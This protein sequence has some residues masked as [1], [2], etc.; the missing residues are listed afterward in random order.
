[1][2]AAASQWPVQAA[3]FGATQWPQPPA[4]NGTLQWPAG[5]PVTNGASQWPAGPAPLSVTQWPAGPPITNGAT[6]WPAGPPITNG[7]TQWPAGQ[8]LTNG[9]TQWPAA[10]TTW[11]GPPP[12]NNGSMQWPAGPAGFQMPPSGNVPS[13]Q[14]SSSW[15]RY[16]PHRI[17]IVFSLHYMWSVYLVLDLVRYWK[18]SKSDHFYTINVDEIGTATSGAV[19][20]FDYR[21]EGIQCLVYNKPRPGTV[22]LY[23]YWSGGNV[24]DHFYT[25]NPAEIGTTT[26]GRSGA[27]GYVSEG[28]AGYCLTWDH[29]PVPI[30]LCSGNGP[31]LHH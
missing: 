8:P 13:W 4:N 5:P 2:V 21:S 9:A 22:P 16:T 10:T 15:R 11:P 20:R 18:S 24:I 1:M 14:V 27:H 12:I 3:T 26:R 19:G 6:Q 28:I 7:A 31:S 30:L 25:T 23:R 17:H 29:P